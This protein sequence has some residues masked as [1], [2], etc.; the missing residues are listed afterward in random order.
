[1]F[2]GKPFVGDVILLVGLMSVLSACNDSGHSHQHPVDR[3]TVEVGQGRLA[4]VYS[5]GLSVFKGVPYAQPPVGDLRWKAPAPP[6]KWQGTRDA[7]SFG[8]SCMQSDLPEDS[9]Y[10]DPPEE[11]SEDCLS[12]NVWAP[13]DADKLPV[14]VWIYG[15]SLSIGGSSQALYDGSNLAN[16]GTVVVSFNYRLGVLGWLATPELSAESEHDVSGNYGLL[17]QIQALQWV[18]DNIDQFGGDP[19]NL[20]IMGESAGA[21]SVSY[22][23]TSPLARDLFDKAISQSAN[24][25]SLTMLKTAANGL[26]SSEQIGTN[27]MDKAGAKDIGELRAMTPE[28][29]AGYAQQVGFRPEG[30]VDGWALPDQLVAVF[31]AG[32]QA[33]VPLLAGFNEGEVRSQPALMAPPVDDVSTYESK[34]RDLY[35][36]LA[37][38]FLTLYPGSDMDYSLM[39]TARD[40]IYG[41]ATERMVREQTKLGVPAYLYRFDHCYPAAQER[42]LC[43]FHASELPFVFGY[44]G[45]D[46]PLTENWPRPEGEKEQELSDA[47]INYWASFAATGVPSSPGHDE[48]SA[49]GTAGNYMRFADQPIADTDLESGMFELQEEVVRRRRLA[50]QQWFTNV[51]LLASPPIPDA[52]GQPRP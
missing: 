41:W 43:A 29:L 30:T 50:G 5:N 49:Y 36:D 21:F 31:D 39:A 37:D 8:P 18:R 46:A 14:I 2:F 1:M 47:M 34:I 11:M 19:D 23:L 38:D 25:R 26:P 12:L 15:G 27:L 22:L 52:S 10:R 9:I 13:S 35:G 6:E 42:E 7:E 16:A 44:V 51:G 40:A 28:E 20:T 32:D 48:W 4:G 17:D 45:P 3:P 24:T 33:R